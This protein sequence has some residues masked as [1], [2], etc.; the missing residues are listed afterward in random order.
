MR[1]TTML[2]SLTMTMTI[3]ATAVIAL[4]VPGAVTADGESTHTVRP[5]D[6]LW[7]IADLH[8]VPVA[9][10]VELNGLRVTST[11]HP[12]Q[13][14][15][16]P[17]GRGADGAPSAGARVTV[18]PGDS[19]WA[20]AERAG[21]T[22]GALLD[23][24]DLAD[25]STIHP[26]Q[27]VMLPAAAPNATAPSGTDTDTDIDTDTDTDGAGSSSSYIV[28]QGDGL[29][30]IAGRHGIG[31]GALLEAN[32]LSLDSVIH[33]GQRLAIPAASVPTEV[34]NGAHLV[35][36][37]RLAA[38]EVGIPADLLMAVAYVESRWD[39]AARSSSGAVGVGQL[40]PRTARWIA[41]DLVGES[42]LDVTDVV[43]NIRMSAHLLA[44]LL[45]EAGGD[46]DV[47]LAMYLQ[48]V[49]GVRA[50]GVSDAAVAYAA[51]VAAMRSRFT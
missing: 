41:D 12:G 13:E 49:Y 38:A 26:G 40:M 14:L 16:I 30:T 39:Q 8:D 3:T 34:A 36:T 9:D 17:G 10:L 27:S 24:N 43:D 25:D 45:D 47:A 5:G 33:P 31:I 1:H 46:T 22:L 4:A 37:F 2:A 19:L 28:R 20:I 18:R 6:S 51:R 50:N 42:G 29:I 7:L 23:V 35:P 15:R 48:G 44:W 32:S 21:V 11:I